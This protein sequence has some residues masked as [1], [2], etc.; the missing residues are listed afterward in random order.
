MT[1]KPNINGTLY[2][3]GSDT[4]ADFLL[5]SES[6]AEHLGVQGHRF[7]LL[8]TNAEVLDEFCPKFDSDCENSFHT[9]YEMRD[10][11]LFKYFGKENDC[12]SV[13][14][15]HWNVETVCQVQR[16]LSADDPDAV[17]L[18]TKLTQEDI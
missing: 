4:D 10:G 16:Q 9:V 15:R 17:R 8:D 7:W 5:M 6:V 13:S 11:T 14:L 12:S 2:R 18:F 1:T 3:C